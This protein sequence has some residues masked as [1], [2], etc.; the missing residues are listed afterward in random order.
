M[1]L[2]EFPTPTP[3]IFASGY[4]EL[5]TSFFVEMIVFNQQTSGE[6]L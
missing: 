1:G 5:R 3:Y 4:I 2:G 6:S